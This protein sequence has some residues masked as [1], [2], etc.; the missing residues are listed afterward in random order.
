SVPDAK[1]K[2]VY[3][4]GIDNVRFRKPVIP[5]DQ[6]RFELEVEKCRTK[7][8]KMHGRAFVGEDLV[9]EADMISSLVDK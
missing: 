6:L 7:I 9:C 4:V 8:A 1:N 3:F 5:G 2:V